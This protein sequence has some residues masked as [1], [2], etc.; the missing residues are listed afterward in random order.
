MYAKL[1]ELD[2]NGELYFVRHKLRRFFVEFM[3]FFPCVRWESINSFSPARCIQIPH[4]NEHLLD[5]H[6]IVLII[7]IR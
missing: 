3:T 6:S 4:G 5:P 7:V 1:T 2:R